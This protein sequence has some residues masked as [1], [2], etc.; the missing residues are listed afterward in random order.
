MDNGPPRGEPTTARTDR[1][2]QPRNHPGCFRPEPPPRT[3]FVEQDVHPQQGTHGGG[4]ALEPTGEYEDPV[5][6]DLPEPKIEWP[7]S[8][9]PVYRYRGCP[10]TCPGRGDLER[11]GSPIGPRARVLRWW[12]GTG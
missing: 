6:A 5:V 4:D 7:R 9:R 12:Y 11:P 2:T 10:Q 3:V 8:R 1:R